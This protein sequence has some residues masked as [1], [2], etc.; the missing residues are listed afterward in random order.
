M[1]DGNK[2]G[3]GWAGWLLNLP[4]WLSSSTAAMGCAAVVGFWMDQESEPGVQKQ[5]VVGIWVPRVEGFSSVW[6]S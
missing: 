5:G 3:V 1:L 4:L 6:L 2:R